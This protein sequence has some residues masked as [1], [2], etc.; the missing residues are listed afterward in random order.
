[1]NVDFRE[2]AGCAFGNE[3]HG[4]ASCFD[5]IRNTRNI[6]QQQ[7]QEHNQLRAKCESVAQVSPIRKLL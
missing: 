5:G 2:W 3:E 4:V 7:L 6:L 1:L